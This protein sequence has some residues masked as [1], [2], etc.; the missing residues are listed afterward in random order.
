VTWASSNGAAATIAAGGL[1]TAVAA[2]TTA[3]SATSGAV[4]G[5]TLLTVTAPALVSIEVTPSDASVLVG[6]TLQ[7]TA[8]GHYTNGAQQ[9]LTAQVTW[10][11]SNPTVPIDAGGLA[12]ASAT[13]AG[14]T[15][16]TATLGAVSGG[17]TLSV[18]ALSSIAVTPAD[19]SVLTG[20]T[21]QFT[22]TGTYA[23]SSVRDLTARVTWE[24]SNPTVAAINAAGLASAS[25]SASGLTVIS[26]GFGTVS[27]STTLT[28]VAVLT[29][30]DVTPANPSVPLGLT[31][32][33]TATGRYSDGTTLDLTAQVA[34]ASSVT[35]V[36]TIDASG[37]AS[38]AATGATTIT[39]TAGSVIG[40]ISLTVL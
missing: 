2:G 5:S 15:T 17:T 19:P 32:A 25:P 20:A 16:I 30:I 27:G 38:T 10:S 22:A 4:S 13:A 9:D 11:S 14:A 33:F 36:A 37:L 34:W 7:L 39:A 6:F 35:A 40:N 1:A 8:T 3:I 23:D 28:V 12:T 21:Q 31:Q 18:V 29:A 26:A 24:S